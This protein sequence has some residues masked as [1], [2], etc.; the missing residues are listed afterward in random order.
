MTAF[1]PHLT[2]VAA[3]RKDET[4]SLPTKT[5]RPRPDVAGGQRLLERFARDLG[6]RVELAT[7]RYADLSMDEK[8]DHLIAQDY[9]D[10]GHQ[11]SAESRERYRKKAI[12]RQMYGL[13]QGGKN[14]PDLSY[15]F[16]HGRMEV[17]EILDLLAARLPE[18]ASDPYFPVM[19]YH[20]LVR[21]DPQ[22]A[23]PLL[24]G[25]SDKEKAKQH[26][27]LLSGSEPMLSSTAPR[28]YLSHGFSDDPIPAPDPDFAFA[29]LEVIPWQ[30]EPFRCFDHSWVWG[31]CASKAMGSYRDDYLAWLQSLPPGRDRDGAIKRALA[32]QDLLVPLNSAAGIFDHGRN[33]N[34]LSPS[35]SV[36]A[37]WALRAA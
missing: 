6:P 22:R 14:G 23:E 16:R 7:S 25:L 15:A 34:G 28:T 1:G 9:P 33:L 10:G 20:C 32:E 2:E 21:Q 13:V 31:S 11:V 17:Q 8:I 19:L 37:G 3:S 36:G 29:M 27:S 18:H 12:L 24:A 26:D 4:L 35:A 5:N 30:R